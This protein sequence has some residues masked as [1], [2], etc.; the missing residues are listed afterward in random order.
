MSLSIPPPLLAEFSFWL[1]P[2]G[3]LWAFLAALNFWVWR[4]SKSSGHL[5]MLLGAAWLAQHYV[6]GAFDMCVIG[7]SNYSLSVVLGSLL[8]AIGFYLSVKPLVADDLARARHWMKSKLGKSGAAPYAPP[9]PP[10]APTPFFSP[11]AGATPLPPPAPS[12]A[13]YAP[14]KPPDDLNLR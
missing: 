10:A 13:R 4:R 14:A 11:T 3:L 7:R 5:V 1:L 12:A 9:A 2:S 6:L 8:F